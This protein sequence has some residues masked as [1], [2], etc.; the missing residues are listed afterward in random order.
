MDIEELEDEIKDCE[1]IIYENE[2]EIQGDLDQ[3]TTKIH[4]FQSP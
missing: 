2:K 3:D 1:Y 4:K